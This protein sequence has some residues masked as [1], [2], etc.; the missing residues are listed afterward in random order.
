MTDE[1]I[2]LIGSVST[3][4]DLYRM[5]APAAVGRIALV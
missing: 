2:D 5:P 1:R 3:G 4:T